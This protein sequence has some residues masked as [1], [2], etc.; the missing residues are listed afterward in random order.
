VRQW[1]DGR[2]VPDTIQTIFEYPGGVRLTYDATLAN[3]F[4]GTF[5]LMQGSDSTVLLR[6]ARAWMFKE[7]DATALGWEVYARKDVVGDDNGIMLVANASK[8]LALGKEPKDFAIPDPKETPLSYACNAFLDAI[9]TG[10]NNASD[11]EAGFVATVVAL[12]A[13]EA[14]IKGDKI[15]ITKEMLALV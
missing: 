13:N 3:S 8:L 7:A 6:G 10:K 11:A 2:A 1:K 12:K 4:G 15:A 9:R 5:E 14:I